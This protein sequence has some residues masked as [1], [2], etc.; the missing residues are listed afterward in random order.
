MPKLPPIK[1][2]NF[3]VI[4]GK[5]AA[6]NEP[7]RV[8]A[9]RL[10]AAEQDRLD[11]MALELRQRVAACS[12]A[13]ATGHV[14]AIKDA[15]H[16]LLDAEYELTGDSEAFGFL[17]DQY[18]ITDVEYKRHFEKVEAARKAKDATA[19]PKG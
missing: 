1:S 12:A 7:F 10:I 15:I 13:I 2:A 8:L 4:E 14:P 9:E 17:D 6:P 3:E 19:N 16:Y 5:R 18:G 11:A